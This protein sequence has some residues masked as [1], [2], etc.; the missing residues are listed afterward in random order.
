M[1]VADPPE[2]AVQ[3]TALVDLGGTLCDTGPALREGLLRLRG[4][5]HANAG[6]AIESSDPEQAETERRL[7]MEAPGFWRALP[8]L[9]LGFDLL[10]LLKVEGFRVH[11]VTK[12]PYSAPQAWADKV[13]WCRRH[14][15][16]LPVVVTDD[17]S[18]VHGHV[19]V[20]D[21]L[22]YVEGWQL[23]WSTGLAI[24]PAQS[25]NAQAL[26]GPRMLRYD[27]SNLTDVQSALRAR[28]R[29]IQ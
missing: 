20:D 29:R 12:G 1:S 2:P 22:P 25:W 14:V 4:R 26:V 6:F 13:M 9:R 10:G 15:P 7:V 24:I 18:L 27:G 21:W 16:G 3:P 11:I 17:K 19:L 23:R 28:L 8:T 5:E